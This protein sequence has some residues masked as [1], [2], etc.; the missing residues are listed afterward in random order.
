MPFWMPAK[1]KSHRKTFE[2]A[3]GRCLVDQNCFTLEDLEQLQEVLD[4]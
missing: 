3:R 1:L 2:R 4:K